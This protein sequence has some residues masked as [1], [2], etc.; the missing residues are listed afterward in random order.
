MGLIFLWNYEM[1]FKGTWLNGKVT[2][3]AAIFY[4]D[5]QNLQQTRTL[6]CGYSFVSNVGSAHTTGLELDINAKASRHF[7]VGS[8]MGFLNAIIDESGPNLE[9]E[10]GDRIT[11][12]P[13]LTANI[14]AEYATKIRH[15]GRVYIYGEIQHV[16]ERF[17]TFSP[18][19]VSQSHLIFDAY[20]IINARIGVQ[21]P[22]QEFSIFVNNLT[23]TAA[24]FGNIFSVAVD[25][26]GRPRYAT[27]RPITIG[28]QSR[29]YF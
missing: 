21:Y 27:N 25:V 29:V 15:K 9:A 18:E 26:P 11:F 7:K 20:T 22:N 16:G 28:V 13:N 4:N 12:T 5:W 19:D 10:K 1:G 8:G 3:N 2:T 17:N 14:N 6:E 23:D 24:N